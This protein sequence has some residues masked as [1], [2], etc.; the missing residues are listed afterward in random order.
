M[1]L[2]NVVHSPV[3]PSLASAASFKNVQIQHA[4]D[5]AKLDLDCSVS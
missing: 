2:C 5:E 3:V 1:R 4:L